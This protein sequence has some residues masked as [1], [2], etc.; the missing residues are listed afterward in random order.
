MSNTGSLQG[1]CLCG[2]V[3]FKAVPKNKDVGVC[4]CSMCR[5]WSGGPLMVLDCGDAVEY[6]D[7]SDIEVFKSSKWGERGFCKNCGTA[8]FWKLKGLD[9]YFV[10]VGT[11][12][13]PG[14]LKFAK[15]D[16]Y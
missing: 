15:R 12:D 9:Y 2:T 13:N 14:D 5:R 4:H 8:L 7:E 1:K 3:R 6:E 10:P 11:F 16:V